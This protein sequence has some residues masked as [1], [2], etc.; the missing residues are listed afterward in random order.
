MNTDLS[1]LDPVVIESDEDNVSL[2]RWTE[3]G[4]DRLYINGV[5]DD[6]YVDLKEMA[7]CAAGM[8]GD[9]D[10]EHGLVEI[11]W[12]EGWDGN[13]SHYS[14]T[15]SLWGEGVSDDTDDSNAQEAITDGG[16]DLGDIRK[17]TEAREAK[18]AEMVGDDL[19]KFAC[20]VCNEHI[21]IGSESVVGSLGIGWYHVDHL[22][23]D[24]LDYARKME[25]DEEQD[26]ERAQANQEAN[27]MYRA[28]FGDAARGPADVGDADA[29]LAGLERDLDRNGEDDGDDIV[30]DGGDREIPTVDDFPHK[31]ERGLV[32]I[33]NDEGYPI[34]GVEYHHSGDVLKPSVPYYKIDCHGWGSYQLYIGIDKPNLDGYRQYLEDYLTIEGEQDTAIRPGELLIVAQQVDQDELDQGIINPPDEHIEDRLLLDGREVLETGEDVEEFAIRMMEELFE[35]V[36][37]SDSDD[38][39]DGQPMTDGGQD[40]AAKGDYDEHIEEIRSLANAVIEISNVDVPVLEVSDG[41]IVGEPGGRDWIDVEQDEQH[42]N[43]WCEIYNIVDD[44]GRSPEIENRL[45]PDVESY[46]R[47]QSVNARTEYTSL[48]VKVYADGHIN[49]LAEYDIGDES[50]MAVMFDDDASELD[51]VEIGRTVA[52]AELSLLVRA[53]GSDAAALDYWQTRRSDGWYRQQSWADVRGVGR[54]SVNDQVRKAKDALEGGPECIHCGA[55]DDES[56]TV[57]VEQNQEGE[58]YTVCDICEPSE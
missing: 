32:E 55:V 8:N 47:Y 21:P 13:W 52:S 4:H 19:D 54:Q 44:H 51:P 41:M 7:V 17:T 43:A 33:E 34:A 22:S 57:R 5:K 46:L 37:G 48:G 12:R 10:E 26:F 58:H 30:T 31:N 38:D 27:E 39:D 50:S 18:A 36:H 3:Y 25:A 45:L 9:V 40:V 11:T 1:D 35:R 15:I 23:E 53:T 14:L 28:M 16:Q 20:P 29:E 56:V 2:S 42:W 6:A 24:E 49:I